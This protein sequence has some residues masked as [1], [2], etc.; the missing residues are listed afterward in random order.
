MHV[1]AH[2]STLLQLLSANATQLGLY[3]WLNRATKP[4]S[5]NWLDYGEFG[6]KEVR[7]CRIPILLNVGT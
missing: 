4:R 2:K 7:V 5:H 3:W 1:N 6:L